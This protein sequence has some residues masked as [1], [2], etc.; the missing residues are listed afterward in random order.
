MIVMWDQTF[1]LRHVTCESFEDYNR[2]LDEAIER[3]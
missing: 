1:P 2:L 3:G